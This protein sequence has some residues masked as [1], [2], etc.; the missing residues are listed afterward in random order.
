[1][2]SSTILTIASSIA[3]ASAGVVP[4]V[5]YD[6]IAERSDELVTRDCSSHPSGSYWTSL[7]SPVLGGCAWYYCNGNNIEKWIDCGVSGCALHNG[8]PGC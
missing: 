6:G 1:M 5:K 3:A 7:S 8:V 2:R 4:P